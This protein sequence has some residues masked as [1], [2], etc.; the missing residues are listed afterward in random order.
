MTEKIKSIYVQRL[1]EVQDQVHKFCLKPNGF[2]KKGR[3]HCRKT[4]DGLYQVVNFQIG[5]AYYNDTDKFWVNIGVRVP[6]A[7]ERSLDIVTEKDFYKEYECNIRTTLF[8]FVGVSN[9][10]GYN[11]KYLSLRNE[12]VSLLAE[13]IISLIN[14]YVF[15]MFSDLESRD[16]VLINRE[17]YLN[18]TNLFN[19]AI[20]LETSMIYAR[21][22]D[23]GKANEYINRQ[24]AGS[25]NKGNREYVKKIAD[26]LGLTIKEI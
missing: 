26:K 15:P 12:N 19:N 4:D 21:K 11:N 10:K 3:T 18:I 9:Y 20:D 25:T 24:Y 23:L 14:Q 6:E 1:D 13:E 22:G 2:V 17:K 8:R 7:F 5:Q 16:K